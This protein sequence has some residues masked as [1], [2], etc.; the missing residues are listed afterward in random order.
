[1]KLEVE[2]RAVY[3]TPKI[4]PVNDAARALAQIAGTE[5]LSARTLD[6]AKKLGHSVHEVIKSRLGD[7]LAAN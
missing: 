5:T 1:M 6:L 2:I 3:G 7:A 4:Y